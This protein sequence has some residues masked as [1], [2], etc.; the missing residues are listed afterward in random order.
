M[1]QLHGISLAFGGHSILDR[2]S[3]AIRPQRRIGLIGANGA[4]KTTLLRILAGLQDV[5][6]GQVL[7]QARVGYL[8]QDTQESISGR[9]VL[10]E[11]MQAFAHVQ[12]LQ[13]KEHRLTLALEKEPNYASDR[14]ARLLD[15]LAHVQTRIDGHDPSRLKPRTEAVLAGLGFEPDD[16]DRPLDTMSGGYRMRVSLAQI[17]LREP[18]LL[19]LDEPTNHLDIVSIAWLEQYLKDYAGSVVFVSHDRYFLNRMATTIA[20]LG[21]GKMTEYAGNYSFY[22]AER[23]KRHTLEMAAYENQQREIS[24]TK[25]F[26]ER[27]RYKN[28]KA[29][30]VQSRIKHLA[31]MERLLPPEAA[32]AQIVIRFPSPCKS[33]RTVMELSVFSKTYGDGPG[34]FD[35]AGPLHIARGD[36]IALVGKNGA[37]KS[38]LARML[39][40]SE[41]FEGRR[42]VGHNV[43]LTIFAQHQA[44]TLSSHHTALESLQQ[45]SAGQNEGTLRTLLGA[46]LL[47]GDDVFK[48]VHVLSGGE[49]SRLALARTLVNPAN[50]LILDEPTNHLDIQSIQVLIEALRQY[51]GTFVVVSHDRHFL[52]QIVNTVWYVGAGSVQTYKGN[53]SDF[54]WYRMKGT[55]RSASAAPSTAVSVTGLQ[56][57]ARSG[58]PKTREA[59]RQEAEARQRVHAFSLQERPADTSRLTSAQ[60]RALCD[61]TEGAIQAAESQRRDTEALLADSALY[62]DPVRVAD[63]T[64]RYAALGQQLEALYARWEALAEQ[65]QES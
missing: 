14:Y 62:T 63:A 36:K 43:D 58:G 48:P 28:T 25:R 40:G 33:G 55:A 18:D 56:K 23:Q 49:K 31:K 52:D 51:T 20:H 21:R 6:K 16:M 11:A 12:D 46:F 27:F 30:Q 10:E 9:T 8:A 2:L 22:L 47:R 61:E 26:I 34:V 35:R 17:L 3:W 53:Y 59:K 50:F 65:L 5:D 13:Q 42:E 45:V 39:H 29:R 37:G 24:Q 15:S 54:Q 32:E 41:P 64:T 38:T 60:L 57:R 1:V 7:G 4:G 44:E 19:L